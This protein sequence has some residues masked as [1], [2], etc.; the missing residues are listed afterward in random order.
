MKHFLKAAIASVF[1]VAA[2]GVVGASAEA[3][4]RDYR[5]DRCEDDH[6][7]RSHASNYYDYY[8]KDRYYRAG[9]YGKSG[10]SVSLR[11][12]DDGYDRHGRYDRRDRYDR[13]DRHD[14]RRGYH[15]NGYRGDRARI[16]NREVYDTRYRARIYLTEELVHRRGGPRLICTVRVEGPDARYVPQRRLRNIARNDCSRRAKINIYS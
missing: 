15:R 5:P 11:F 2:L 16:V 1:G 12:G 9:A 7:H 8:A 6:D 4:D 3:R 14:R 10:L 13:Y